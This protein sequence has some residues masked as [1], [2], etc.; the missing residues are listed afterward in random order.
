MA[1]RPSI[2]QV[3][4]AAVAAGEVP[5]VTATAAT[6]DGV[7]HESAHGRRS[8]AGDAPMTMDTVFR[9]ASMTKAVT[10]AAAMAGGRRWIG[11]LDTADAADDPAPGEVAGVAGA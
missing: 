2:D 7:I 4:Q 5:G 3:L 6:A 10:G 9:I 8:L 1:N 11:R